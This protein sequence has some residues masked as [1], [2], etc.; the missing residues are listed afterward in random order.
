[1]G[2]YATLGLAEDTWALNERAINEDAFLD[3]VYEH[4]QEREEMFFNALEKTRKR[5]MCMCF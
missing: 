1:M 5:I 4:H 2:S 3:Q